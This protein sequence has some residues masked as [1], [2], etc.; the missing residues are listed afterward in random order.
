[1]TPVVTN[2]LWAIQ[3]THTFYHIIDVFKTKKTVTN[4]ITNIGG[5]Y[6][7]TKGIGTVCWSWKDDESQLQ[8]KKLK[9][10]STFLI[11]Q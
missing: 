4:E 10:F 7:H 9:G 8:S 5:K 1:M 6:L 11:P 3:S 2:W